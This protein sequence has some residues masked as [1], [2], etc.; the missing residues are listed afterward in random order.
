MALLLCLLLLTSLTL[1]GLSAA[2]ET[3]MQ[4]RLADNL[5]ETEQARHQALAAQGWAEDWLLTRNGPM[6]GTCPPPCAGLALHAGGTLPPNPENQDFSWWL[7]N[8][9]EAGVDPISNERLAVFGEDG[10]TPP[11][12]IVEA[13]YESPSYDERQ[14]GTQ[15][16]YRILARGTSRSGTSVHVAESIVTRP[17]APAGIPEPPATEPCPGFDATFECGRVAWR[18][19][20]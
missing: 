6:P 15:A 20:R 14:P 2:S 16:W 13:L 4:G 8:G 5:R 17:W 18:A 9:Y 3:L 12:W 19:L 11:A 7:A 10:A 1:L